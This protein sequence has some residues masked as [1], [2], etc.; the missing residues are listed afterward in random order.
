MK[1]INRLIAL[2]LISTILSACQ[3]GSTLE[4]TSEE[5]VTQSPSKTS[6]SQEPATPTL[7]LPDIDPANAI[8]HLLPGQDVLITTIDMM[9]H[10]DG[11]AIGGI[12]APNKHILTTQDGGHTW[13]DVTPPETDV[14]YKIAHAFFLSTY[15]A[16]VTYSYE[17]IS[18]IPT[19]AIVWH[20]TDAGQTWAAQGLLDTRIQF[21]FYAPSFFTFADN[22]N[23]WLL[24]S[25][26]AGMS[27]D[28][29]AAYR[30]QDSGTT[31]T[32]IHDPAN[33]NFLQSCCKTGLVFGYPLSGFLDPNA[34]Q[35]GLLTAEQGPYN[36][37]Y[38]LITPDGG[39][40]WEQIDFPS[41]KSNPNLFNEYYCITHS[42]HIFSSFEWRI[43]LSCPGTNDTS[44]VY[45]EY[46]TTDRG[47]TWSTQSYPSGDLLW[48]N[49]DSGFA[50][51]RKI[52]FTTAI[53]PEWQL[54]KTVTW[55]G[56]F[57]FI[58]ETHGW[59]IARDGGEIV[60]VFTDDGGATWQIIT[61]Q[62]IPITVNPPLHPV[63]AYRCTPV[64]V[65]FSNV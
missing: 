1:N 48:L 6:V 43:G 41:P 56:Q 39:I 59:A 49:P 25:V 13:Q 65:F 47:I 61:P 36:T 3:I 5:K 11:W 46:R 27:H 54:I 55:D 8:S 51:S 14:N 24:I 40:T 31:W 19:P 60:L 63:G 53:N 18:N 10:F 45:Y 9:N 17:N 57:D 50:L 58:N 52:Y 7:A 2:L 38:F 15:T 16:W 4:P 22:Q 34:S 30:T 42:P 62:I 21:E 29:T 44:A 26:G 35:L 28:Y 37:P 23:G 12:K 32:L 33:S 64:P 20:T